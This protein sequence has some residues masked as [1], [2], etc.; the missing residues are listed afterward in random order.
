MIDHVFILL[1]TDLENFFQEVKI[2]ENSIK[3]WLNPSSKEVMLR[4]Q[5]WSM[6]EKYILRYSLYQLLSGLVSASEK[7]VGLDRLHIFC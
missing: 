4:V 7:T 2:R 5:S 1:Y 3:F 6:I